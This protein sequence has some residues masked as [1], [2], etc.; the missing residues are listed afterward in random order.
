MASA[1][2]Y[3]AGSD[4]TAWGVQGTTVGHHATLAVAPYVARPSRRIPVHRSHDGMAT[5]HL[6]LSAAAGNRSK[7]C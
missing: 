4:V 2:A 6:R 5:R 7:M 3:V 1:S